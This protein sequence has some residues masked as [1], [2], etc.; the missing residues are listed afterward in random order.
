[1]ETATND[2]MNY[3]SVSKICTKH[4]FSVRRVID[5]LT[6][7]SVIPKRSQRFKK[8][9]VSNNG[10]EVISTGTSLRVIEKE[11]MNYLG[12]QNALDGVAFADELNDVYDTI[13]DPKFRFERISNIS[14][15]RLVFIDAEFKD[16]NYHEVA[17]EVRE[18]G[19]VIEK[20]YFLVKEEF[21]KSL[22]RYNRVPKLKRLKE[23]KQSC[24]IVSRKHI[25][26]LMKKV[27]KSADYIVAHNAYSERNI[28]FK[29]GIRVD[30]S[31]FLCTSKMTLGYIYDRTPSLIELVNHYGIKIQSHF[32]HYAHEDARVAAEIFYTMIESAKKDFNL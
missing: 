15:G 19:K 23:Y 12:E 6:Q 22:K 17:W 20:E 10:L 32:T 27:I 4:N 3:V 24:K 5:V 8:E 21:L 11:L 9:F 26:R 7:N 29:N 18:N 14:N 28:L 16:D 30:K 31:K 2:I 1:M 25:N 13:E